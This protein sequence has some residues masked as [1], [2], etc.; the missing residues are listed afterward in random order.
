MMS[1]CPWSPLV[2]FS[3]FQ[4]TKGS[5]TRNHYF[6]NAASLKSRNLICIHEGYETN[7]IQGRHELGTL[8]E[9]GSD[10]MSSTIFCL[11]N[12]FV[13]FVSSFVEISLWDRR[14]V[15]LALLFN[16]EEVETRRWKAVP[17]PGEHPWLVFALV[18]KYKMLFQRHSQ[19][20]LCPTTLE[21]DIR[22]HKPSR[23]SGQLFS[24]IIFLASYL[25][26]G[27][28]SLGIVIIEIN[29]NK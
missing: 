22:N 21:W 7:E 3:S 9:V 24:F 25:C 1:L 28:S 20:N 8:W 6:M 15:L 11:H 27:P 17:I 13:S 18:F 23:V 19:G 12:G 29:K 5:T 10:L 14:W 4:W 26:L 2:E 16:N